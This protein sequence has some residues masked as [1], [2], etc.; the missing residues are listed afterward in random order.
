MAP[1]VYII[2]EISLNIFF[3]D[4]AAILFFIALGE[5]VRDDGGIL[6]VGKQDN[7]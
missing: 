4:L 7:G 3:H 1:S 5:D 2:H 6:F